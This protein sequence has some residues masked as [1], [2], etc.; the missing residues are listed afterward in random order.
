MAP[1]RQPRLVSVIVP[2][3]NRR[4]SLE[5][6]LRALATQDY[7]GHYEVVVSDDGS[8]D[9][10]TDLLSALE[11]DASLL[12]DRAGR[13]LD[14]VMARSATC[15]G[16]PHARNVGMERARGDLMAFCDDD[17]VVQP[18]WLRALAEAAAEADIVAGVNRRCR[19]VGGQLQ[20]LGDLEGRSR[21]YASPAR[22]F[23]FLLSAQ[24]GNMACWRYVT[25]AIGGWDTTYA[26]AHDVQL[27]WRAQLAGFTLAV[28]PEALVDWAQRA[29]LGQ[30]WSQRFRWG[31][32]DARLMA[33][34]AP[35]GCPQASLSTTLR[36]TL[37]IPLRFP[38]LFAGA[39]ER[40]AYV[41]WV[42]WRCGRLAGSLRYR[43]RCI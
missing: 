9:G 32:E 14:L 41:E 22:Q 30:I 27:A 25:D 24:G 21:C 8:D 35:R 36:R 3:R 33:D 2:T 1:T 31:I 28:A 10:T 17:D 42:S 16:S 5:R 19:E 26:Y 18:N 6:Q 4:E 13:D 34:F 23:G 29:H 37:A 39:E 15:R 20:P 11:R 43:V 38:R 7:Q 12:G 40:R